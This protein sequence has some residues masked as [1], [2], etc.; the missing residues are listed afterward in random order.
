MLYSKD[1]IINAFKDDEL[2]ISTNSITI[3]SITIDSRILTNGGMFFAIKGENNDGHKYIKSAVENGAVCVV[4]EHLPED[5]EAI[6]AS[7]VVV[8]KVCVL[9]VR[10]TSNISSVL[11]N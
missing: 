3:N 8:K 2:Y 6:N 1:D 7:F 9:S 4:C 5:Y 10:F 11:M